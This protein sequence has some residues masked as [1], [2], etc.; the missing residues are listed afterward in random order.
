MS[1][2]VRT[3]L[4]PKLK[5]WQASAPAVEKAP[6]APKEKKLRLPK[7]L[8]ELQKKR[9]QGNHLKPNQEG[10]EWVHNQISQKN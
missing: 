2:S 4:K 10:S 3:T 7:K 5:E 1:D 6:K 8:Q 9:L